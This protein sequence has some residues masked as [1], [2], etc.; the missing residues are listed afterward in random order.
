MFRRGEVP[1]VAVA[2]RALGPADVTYWESA[3][4]AF[5]LMKLP[6]IEG[7]QPKQWSLFT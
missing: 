2:G 4:S 7:L 1:R 6:V 3:L 5:M